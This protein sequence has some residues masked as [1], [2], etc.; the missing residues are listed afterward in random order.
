MSTKSVC[1]MELLVNESRSNGA[2]LVLG[3]IVGMRISIRTRC[4][5]MCE[6]P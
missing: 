4:V 6:T 2:R 3:D 1:I 5:P